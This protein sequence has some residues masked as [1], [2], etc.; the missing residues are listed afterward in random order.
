MKL[1]DV[2][3]ESV[4]KVHATGLA[5]TPMASLIAVCLS[6][7][8]VPTHAAEVKYT[9][10]RISQFYN[11]ADWTPAKNTPDFFIR[12]VQKVCPTKVGA[13][14]APLVALAGI[15][16][17]WL[18]GRIIKA[19]NARL[20]KYLQQ[21]TAS[22]E[23]SLRF[24]DIL[25]KDIWS[26]YDDPISCVVMQ[27]LECDLDEGKV[28]N[29]PLAKCDEKDANADPAVSIAIALRDYGNHLRAY[30]IA[31]NA[32]E[33]KA[34]H[35]KGN[36]TIAAALEIH[37]VTDPSEKTG[38]ERWTTGTVALIAE[39]FP[40]TKATKKGDP[41]T[42]THNQGYFIQEM[43][44][45]DVHNSPLW[46][47]AAVLPSPPRFSR[48]S[49]KPDSIDTYA[50]AAIQIKVAEVGE[51]GN[52]AKKMANLVSTKE[53]ELSGVLGTAIKKKLDIETD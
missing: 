33:L 23:N 8:F 34:R 35:T 14:S 53:D 46:A 11:Y 1:I 22:Y 18:A 27:R 19:G 2:I 4:K 48:P 44:T 32:M 42:A 29:N 10:V 51:P 50:L 40:A 20:E 6:L 7:A 52:F 43:D 25:N 3:G 49:P 30:P 31:L 37:G 16:V 12:E 5:R 36:A 9:E 38:G 47:A 24:V 26:A 39:S 15:F 21:H 13:K 28:N 17:D 41:A 45:D